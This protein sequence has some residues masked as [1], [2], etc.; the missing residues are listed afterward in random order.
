MVADFLKISQSSS[1]HVDSFDTLLGLDPEM[2]FVFLWVGNGVAAKADVRTEKNGSD[3]NEACS[4]IVTVV[5]FQ[6][7]HYGEIL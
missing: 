5:K 2:H 3:F 6:R 4:F 7:G 1:Q